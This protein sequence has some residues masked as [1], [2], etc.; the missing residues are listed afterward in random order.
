MNILF[1][2]QYGGYDDVSSAGDANDLNNLTFRA[3]RFF[4]LSSDLMDK[5]TQLIISFFL[6]F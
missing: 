4:E 5:N 2:F 3:F 1:I 6:S